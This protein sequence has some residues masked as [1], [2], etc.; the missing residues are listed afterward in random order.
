MRVCRGNSGCLSLWMWYFFLIELD[1]FYSLFFS[2]I[3]KT[4]VLKKKHVIKLYEIKKLKLIAL[5]IIIVIHSVLLSFSF[6]FFLL[7]FLLWFVFKCIFVDFIFLNWDWWEFNFVIF[8]FF[9]TLYEVNMVYM[10]AK[11]TQVAPS[12]EFGGLFFLIELDFF[13]SLFFLI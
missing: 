8:F 2:H 1:L 4:I 11:V 9:L 6:S 5:W 12:Y 3:I 7:I 10:F 13:Y